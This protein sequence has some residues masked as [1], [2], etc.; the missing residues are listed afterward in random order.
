MYGRQ[1]P[2]KPHP[3]GGELHFYETIKLK[4]LINKQL[5]DF[6]LNLIQYETRKS[7]KSLVSKAGK[8]NR[9]MK[10]I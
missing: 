5:S 8:F 2:R 10:G 4:A 7:G 1:V 9:E 6:M 3:V